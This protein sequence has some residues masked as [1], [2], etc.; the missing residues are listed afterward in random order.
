[1]A[2]KRKGLDTVEIAAR[3]KAGTAQAGEDEGITTAVVLEP[4][5]IRLLRAVAIV[6][7][8]RGGGRT[9]VSAIIRELIDAHESELRAEGGA[10]VDSMP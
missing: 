8:A 9:S 7:Q 6:R 3:A 2:R 4:D 1:M 5:Q 10:L